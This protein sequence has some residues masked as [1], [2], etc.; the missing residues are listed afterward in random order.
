MEKK[1]R[2]VLHIIGAMDRGGAE[3]LIMN[4]YRV[5]DRNEIQFDFLVHETRKCDY[6]DEIKSLGGE[7]YHTFRFNGIN[8]L[9]YYLSCKKFFSLHRDYIA[10]HVHIGSSASLVIKAAHSQGLFAIAHS[11]NTNPPLSILEIGFRLF[12]WP[13]RHLADWY[14]ACSEQAGIDRFGKKVATGSRFSVLIN[15]IDVNRYRFD[16]EARNRTRRELGVK[17]DVSLIC[18]VGRFA[19]QKNHAFLLHVFN[20]LK[21]LDPSSTL[22]L[23]GRGPLEMKTKELASKLGL[24]GSVLFL[25]IREDVPELLM[26]ADLFL[27]P[28]VYEGLGMAAVEAQAAGLPCL[29]SDSLPDLAVISPQAQKV[30]LALSD[31]EW[32]DKATDLLAASKGTER[33][34]ASDLVAKAGF[35]IRSSAN[36]LLKLYQSHAIE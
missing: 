20:K 5:I 29:L 13:T 1:P 22:L 4:I 25:G 33:Q 7:I 19:P 23:I 24:D 14:L 6:D 32:A 10:V 21:R 9:P 18:H 11:H 36:M 31:S 28:S 30:P 35:D 3:T 27:F 16:A 26:A 12:S 17:D 15:G 2:R 8:A 34:S